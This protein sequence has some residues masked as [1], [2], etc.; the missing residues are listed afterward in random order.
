MRRRFPDIPEA[1]DLPAEQQRRYF[2]NTVS[3][4]ITH[5]SEHFPLLLVI[6]DVHWADEPTLLLIEHI[7]SGQ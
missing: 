3:S 2:F 7:A 4:F 1:L 6:D 5:G